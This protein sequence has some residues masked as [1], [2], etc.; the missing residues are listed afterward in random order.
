[1]N[2]FLCKGPQLQF[3]NNLFITFCWYNCIQYWCG[4]YT[5]LYSSI[6]MFK[7]MNLDKE[8]QEYFLRCT[9]KLQ[10]V[11]KVVIIYTDFCLTSMISSSD[12]MRC[13]HESV[14]DL[15]FAWGGCTNSPG[16]VGAKILFWQIVPKPAWQEFG[17]QVGGACIQNFTM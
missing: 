5:K 3:P 13:G 2:G 11:L 15:G 4:L 9:S 12:I 8:M 14:A 10:N 16:G 17:P 7:L 6:S 1:M